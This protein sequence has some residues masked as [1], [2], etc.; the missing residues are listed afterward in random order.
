MGTRCFTP[1]ILT[2][3]R[4]DLSMPVPHRWWVAEANDSVVGFTG[5]CPSRDPINPS[6]GEIDTIAVDPAWWRRGIGRAL[7]MHSVDYLNRDGYREAILWTLTNYERGHRFYEATGW[8]PDGG[9]RDHGRQ[10]RYHRRLV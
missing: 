10:I 3:W 2:Q 6:V 4:A 9:Q 7:M 5:I 1:D 8:K